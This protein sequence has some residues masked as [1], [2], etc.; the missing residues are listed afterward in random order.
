M[1]YAVGMN[2]SSLAYASCIIRLWRTPSTTLHHDRLWLA[3]VEWLPTGTHTYFSSP[4]LLFEHLRAV[5]DASATA[6]PSDEFSA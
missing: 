3:Q 5:F 6:A 1:R 2:E 4:N